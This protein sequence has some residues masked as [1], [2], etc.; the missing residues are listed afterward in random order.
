MKQSKIIQQLCELVDEQSFMNNEEYRKQDEEYGKWIDILERYLN[1]KE[2][3]KLFKIYN[4]FCIE[5]GGLEVV[6]NELYFKEGFLCGARLALEIC[7]VERVE[8]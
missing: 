2:D 8:K 6:T 5:Q 4:N 7:G 3:K 1:I